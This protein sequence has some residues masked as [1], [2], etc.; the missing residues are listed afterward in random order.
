MAY[1]STEG[2]I[3]KSINYKDSDKIFTVYTK[4]KGKITATA[5]GVR[6]VT[7]RRGGNLDTLNHISFQ[8]SDSGKDYKY[9]TEAAS[10]NTFAQIKKELKK[11]AQAYYVVEL[12][13]RLTEDEQDSSSIFDLILKTLKLFEKESADDRSVVN[14][15]EVNLMKY[16]GYEISFHKCVSCG[17]PFSKSW[18]SCSV[19]FGLGG[20][21][22][23]ACPHK[24][25]SLSLDEASYL[26]KLS[27][28]R[29]L[30]GSL[31]SSHVDDLLKM[32]IRGIL[33]RDLKS[34]S[35]F[36]LKD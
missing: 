6:K 3:L 2:I 24:G 11:A 25:F 32:Y 20:L 26:G 27:R 35:T 9:I 4:N 12:V 33:D 17:K 22:C 13:H 18:N 28:G 16:L 30:K 36:K 34:I 1:Y 19:N 7:S 8:I 29:L 21:I 10:L 15:F 23:D 14:Y 31:D 5:K